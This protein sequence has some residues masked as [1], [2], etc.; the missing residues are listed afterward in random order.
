MLEFVKDYPNLSIFLLLLFGT[1]KAL[2]LYGHLVSLV[3]A[4]GDS[5]KWGLGV[6]LLPFFNYY[7]CYRHWE[8]AYYPGKF[9]IWGTI[10]F[11]APYV[12]GITLLIKDL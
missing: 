10:L 8:K 4:F 2:F 5:I 12:V 7:Y 11:L 1:G 3:Y 9:L 6:L